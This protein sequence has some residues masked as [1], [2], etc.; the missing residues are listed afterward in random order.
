M[1]RRGEQRRRFD[2]G[3]R[4]VPDHFHVAQRVLDR[5]TLA[6]PPVWPPVCPN[7]V[8]GPSIGSQHRAIAPAIDTPQ[9]MWEHPKKMITDARTLA[10]GAM[11]EADV[12]IAGA[13]A[14]GMTIA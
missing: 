9:P 12:C 7:P 13:G 4:L 11:L 5:H 2:V 3:C 1:L 10:D 8:R 14:A 6:S